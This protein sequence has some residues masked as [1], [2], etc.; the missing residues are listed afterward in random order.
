MLAP[1]VAWFSDVFHY[2]APGGVRNVAILRLTLNH[3]R[4]IVQPGADD[5]DVVFAVRSDLSS[6]REMALD[7][8]DQLVQLQVVSS[9][10]LQEIRGQLEIGGSVWAA[11]RD[12][13]RRRVDPT[14][15]QAA[16]AALSV[17]DA[18]SDEL[19]LAWAAAY[20]RS[21]NA[22][23]AWDHTIKA[24]EHALK[25]VVVPSQ[26]TATLGAVVGALRGQPK[27]FASILR[28]NGIEQHRVGIIETFED[29]LHVIWPNPDRHGDDHLRDPSL[30]ESR[31]VV[32]VGALAVQWARDGVVFKR[33]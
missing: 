14:A 29:L 31:A 19:R 6:K 1:V 13:L 18:A 16:D 25:P 3:I 10:S 2:N 12:G 7:L 8:I 15:Q 24:V 22:S 26:P 27:S 23:D 33:D 9:Q 4:Y 28:D 21:P 17:T 30:E 20:G 11:T 5:W 32:Q